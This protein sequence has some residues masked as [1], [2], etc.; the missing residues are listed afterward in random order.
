[1]PY[2]VVLSYILILNLL[3]I[4]NWLYHARL[5]GY[6]YNNYYTYKVIYSIAGCG[7][8]YIINKGVLVGYKRYYIIYN[9]N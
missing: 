6:F 4:K 9:Y 3:N 8:G 7:H 5:F 1:M 2:I